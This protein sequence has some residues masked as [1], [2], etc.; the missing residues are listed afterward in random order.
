MI[1]IDNTLVS[2]DVIEAYFLCDLAACKGACC[3]EGDS[4]APLE[5]SE[6][7][8]LENA[9]PAVWEYLSAEAQAIIKKQGVAYIDSDGDIV[10]SI[11]NG[12]DCVFTCYDKN[13]NCLCAL[14]KAYKEGKVNFY[15]PVSCHLYPIRITE[16]KDFSAVNYNKW[17]ICKSGCTLGKQNKL[18]L[19]QFLKEPLIRK[20][21]EKWYSALEITARK[22]QDQQAK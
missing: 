21:G 10:T 20:F 9:L 16:Y 13:G 18:P 15:K 8:E 2:L 5:K 3:I 14:E 4:G 11:V 6:L 12:K 1:Q 7:K 19:Y 17:N 22:W